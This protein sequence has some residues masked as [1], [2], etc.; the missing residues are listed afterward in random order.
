MS[1]FF[2]CVSNKIYSRAFIFSWSKRNSSLKFRRLNHLSIYRLR[3]FSKTFHF[4]SFTFSI[5]PAI[6]RSTRWFSSILFFF[7][8][9]AISLIIAAFECTNKHTHTYLN[10]D[11]NISML[12]NAVNLRI[13]IQFDLLLFCAN[14]YKRIH[15]IFALFGFHFEK[16]INLSVSAKSIFHSF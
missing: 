1:A 10:N 12:F 3:N 7:S 16:W 9:T 13:S 4:V 5:F 6:H 11:K 2:V 15:N 8:F 14:V